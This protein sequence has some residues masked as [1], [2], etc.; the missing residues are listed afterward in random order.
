MLRAEFQ[1]VTKNKIVRFAFVILLLLHLFQNVYAFL[2]PEA[3]A[4]N[5]G[6]TIYQQSEYETIE[7]FNE[8]LRILDVLSDVYNSSSYL[9]NIKDFPQL[10]QDQ[11]KNN[12][13]KA[14]L[15]FYQD[16]QDQKKLTAEYERLL[17]LEK[18]EL[19][20]VDSYSANQLLILNTKNIFS[21]FFTLILFYFV[22][23]EDQDIEF[24]LLDTTKTKTAR[25]IINKLLTIFLSSTLFVFLLNGLDLLMIHQW[26]LSVY[27]PIQN[28]YQMADS[29]LS[30]NI[31]QF[32]L[33]NSLMH[34]SWLLISVFIIG[35]SL[36][37]TNNKTMSITI[38]A[39][40][41]LVEYLVYAFVPINSSLAIFKDFNLYT[42][43]IN[44]F[45][46]TQYLRHTWLII[47]TIF[48]ILVL[49]VLFKQVF[50]IEKKTY[51][52]Q[53]KTL[54]PLK[55]TSLWKQ[56]FAYLLWK[57]KLILV[58]IIT[59]TFMVNQYQDFSV[60]VD[61]SNQS[62]QTIREQYFGTITQDKVAA[63]EQAVS[64]QK[65]DYDAFHQL[66]QNE[67]LSNPDVVAQLE[68]LK[69]NAL[70]YNDTLRVY[71]EILQLQENNGTAYFDSDGYQLF[72]STESD[73]SLI[74]NL[75]LLVFGIALLVSL[76]VHEEFSNGL[77]NL[78]RSTILGKKKQWIVNLTILIV[79][80]LVLSL[81]IYG[82]FTLKITKVYPLFEQ[83][84]PIQN[85]ISSTL[86]LTFYQA[87]GI[88]GFNLLIALVALIMICYALST[89]YDVFVVMSITFTGFIVMVGLYLIEP[90]LSP[91]MIVSYHLFNHLTLGIM[92]LIVLLTVI[93]VMYRRMISRLE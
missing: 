34:L 91:L 21:L 65:Q 2:R 44:G 82:L 49:F 78:Q 57:K 86:N 37:L 45:L 83:N 54:L 58:F 71:E 55:T 27:S 51:R 92:F 13:Q 73:Y 35:I 40:I 28:V 4:V 7:E 64:I 80:S 66:R 89:T 10:I 88:L 24:N 79:L 81:I 70:L 41:V 17:A 36:S 23:I 39:L 9:K 77:I 52:H 85:L 67:N 31:L 12:R 90:S 19:E 56:R 22:F 26:N 42:L 53:T 93:F 29:L 87:I 46:T 3:K 11:L 6:L 74:L 47:T 32:V 62:Y 76:M 25:L 50:R 14:A 15:P 59:A 8:E 1:R 68:A 60:T 5:Q 75:G 72:F 43:L 18:I 48:L 69:P 38:Y 20:P 61:P 33:F 84:L 30:M 16:P 63:L